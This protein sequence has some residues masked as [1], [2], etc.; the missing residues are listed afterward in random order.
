MVN[1]YVFATIIVNRIHSY[2]VGTD[3]ITIHLGRRRKWLQRSWR[4]L[5]IQILSATA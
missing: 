1:R 2:V 3:I 4:C 5:Q